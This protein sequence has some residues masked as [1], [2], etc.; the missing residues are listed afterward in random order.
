MRVVEAWSRPESACPA[1]LSF[2]RRKEAGC[3]GARTPTPDKSA[4]CSTGI[5][6]HLSTHVT[7][8]SLK[9]ARIGGCVPPL[10]SMEDPGG[11]S[12]PLS[13]VPMGMLRGVGGV[14]WVGMLWEGKRWVPIERGYGT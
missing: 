6:V 13:A 3:R 12:H 9:W 4:G 5:E 11:T 8:S 10:L 1:V 7:S 14:V 2:V